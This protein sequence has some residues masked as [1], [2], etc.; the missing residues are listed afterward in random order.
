MRQVRNI[1][2]GRPVDADSRRTTDLIDPCTGK[3]LGTAPLSST[4]DVEAAYDSARRA[5]EHAQVLTGGDRVGEDGY[6]FAPTVLGGVEQHDEVVQ[7]E[8]FGPVL[9]V[10]AFG[11]E[12]EALS[13]AGGVDYGLAASVWTRDHARAQ[14]LVTEL[15][16]GCVWVNTHLVL[17]A[18]MPH[19]GFKQSGCGKDLSRYG[20]EDYTRIKH[21]MHNLT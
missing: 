1:I 19:G 17:V 6:F 12:P 15:D 4:A 18:E 9:T 5:F 21:V 3:V 14:R 8:I 2:D 11:A 13:M 7:E 16:F 20:F 10:Q